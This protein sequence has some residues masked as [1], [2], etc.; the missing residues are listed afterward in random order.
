MGGIAGILSFTRGRADARR[1]ERMLDVMRSRGPD[2]QG[3]RRSS[4]LKCALGGCRSLLSEAEAQASLPLTN[5]DDDVWVV[6]D[7]EIDNHRTLRHSLRLD[8]HHFR[9]EAAAEVVVHAYEQYGPSFLDHLHGRF[10]LA[11]W[12]NSRLRLVLARDR[13]GEKPLYWTRID[14][15]MAF[16]SE[17]RAL[18]DVLPAPR[19]LDLEHLP[20]YLTH[21]F[22]MPPNTLFEGIRKLGA[23]ESLTIERGCRLEPATWWSPCRDPRRASAVRTLSGQHHQ[24]NLRV[25]LDS[26]IADRLTA[27]APIAAVLDGQLESLAM[28][29][30]MARLLGRTIDALVADERTARLLAGIAPQAGLRLILAAPPP[31]RDCAGLPDYIAAMDEPL[32]DPA[33]IGDWWTA[34]AMANNGLPIG[35]AAT[36]AGAALLGRDLLTRHHAVS[37]SWRMLRGLPPAG[38]HWGGLLLARLMKALGRRA[39]AGTLR[40]ALDG[41]PPLPSPEPLL[42]DPAAML[43]AGPRGRLSWHLPGEAVGRVRRALPDWISDDELG[44]LAVIE[45]RMTL[46]EGHLPRLDRM[47]MAHSVELRLP[48]L[49]DALID[50]ALA[51]PSDERAPQGR[52]KDLLT[53]ALRGLLPTSAPPLGDIPAPPSPVIGWLRGPLS[54]GFNGA[55]ERGSLFRSGLLD[56]RA[57]LGLLHEH[58]MGRIDHHRALWAL[59]V[60]S[61]WVDHMGLELPGDLA[62][63]APQVAMG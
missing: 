38:R 37:P 12:D 13:L 8:G 20:E 62:E 49:D 48:F 63:P 5:E 39:E 32:S 14:G 34:R 53:R 2:D 52:P 7:G 33:A 50:Y 10:A 55:V 56:R 18:L 22:V 19:R 54:A 31:G 36:G 59:L 43:D 21:G 4:N 27:H 25:L 24:N 6:I 60:L 44:A 16:A 17:A 47:S 57:C 42:D 61:E 45:M 41:E 58:Q 46:A 30:G 51:I 35:L 26:A 11:L 23:G 1:V 3:L 28:A 9:G 40:H 29:A 15:M